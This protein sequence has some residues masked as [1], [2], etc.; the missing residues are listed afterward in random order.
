[1]DKGF[2]AAMFFVMIAIGNIIYQWYKAEEE[3]KKEEN[4]KFQNPK[5]YAQL[6]QM[7][8]ERQMMAH[9]EKRM[10]HENVQTGAGLV[11]S[12]FRGFWS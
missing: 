5:E 1:M 4:F 8:H 2:L 10:R 11:S 7:E 6:K 9:D 12:F 3:R